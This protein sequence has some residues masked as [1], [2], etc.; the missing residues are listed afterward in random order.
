MHINA[1]A[2]IHFFLNGVHAP[3]VGHAYAF[4]RGELY[5]YLHLLKSCLSDFVKLGLNLSS[6]FRELLQIKNAILQVY[7]NLKITRVENIIQ[8][9]PYKLLAGIF[10]LNNNNNQ[11][12]TVPFQY[13]GNGL[14]I[15]V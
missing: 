11:L 9:K 2:E 13:I 7:T 1:R 6:R 3:M 12:P 10:R 15:H 5:M 4:R 14:S 8:M